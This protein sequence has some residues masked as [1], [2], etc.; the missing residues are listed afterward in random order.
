[1]IQYHYDKREI[2]K[3][4]KEIGINDVR[5]ACVIQ[6]I[7]LTNPAEELCLER[8]DTGV[9]LRHVPTSTLILSLAKHKMPKEGWEELAE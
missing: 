6:R 9:Y 3:I 5:N 8:N 1:M 2:M 4:L 7:R